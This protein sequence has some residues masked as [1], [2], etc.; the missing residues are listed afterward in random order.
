[1]SGLTQ[2]DQEVRSEVCK[3]GPGLEGTVTEEVVVLVKEVDYRRGRLYVC[4]H[5]LLIIQCPN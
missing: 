4:K 5:I 2:T 3:T 1:M